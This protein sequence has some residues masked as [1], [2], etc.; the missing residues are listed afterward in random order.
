MSCGGAVA[1]GGR[2][3]FIP[4]HHTNIKQSLH[5]YFFHGGFLCQG[6]FITVIIQ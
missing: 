2:I 5:E 4:A 6:I 3:L 1:F